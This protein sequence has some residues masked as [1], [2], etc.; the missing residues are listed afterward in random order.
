MDTAGRTFSDA[1]VQGARELLFANPEQYYHSKQT[2]RSLVDHCF[3]QLKRFLQD[4]IDKKE[5]RTLQWG[6]NLGR[7][8]E[9]LRSPGGRAPWW[10][11][12]ESLILSEDWAR[13][14]QLVRSYERELIG[15]D[16]SP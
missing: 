15:A 6:F 14:L 9:L 8:M 12:F 7:L 16:A 11:A 3:S 2:H 4:A 10:P 13:A 1:D 5:F